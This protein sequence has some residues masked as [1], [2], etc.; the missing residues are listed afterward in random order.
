VKDFYTTPY[1]EISRN[2]GKRH[3]PK[4]IKQNL[5]KTCRKNSETTLPIAKF[6]YYNSDKFDKAS[7]IIL[8]LNDCLKTVNFKITLDYANFFLRRCHQMR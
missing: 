6:A 5:N 4:R 7:V 3:R 2:F 1:K 8:D